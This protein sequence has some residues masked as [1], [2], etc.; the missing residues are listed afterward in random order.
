MR[1]YDGI[2]FDIDGT[3]WDSTD[4]VA[5]SYN[6]CLL[7]DPSLAAAHP[8][9][10]DILKKEFGKPLI[11]I[12]CDLF[13]E[14]SYKECEK[15]G[16]R[17]CDAENDY[18]RIHTPKPY[19][20]VVEVFHTLSKKLPLF[21]VSNCQKGYIEIFLDASSLAPYV[22]DF[23]SPGDSGKLKADNIRTVVG[24][25]HLSSPVYVGDTYGDYQASK[26][27]GVPFICASYGFGSVPEAECS[28]DRPSDLITMFQEN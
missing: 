8:I 17:L 10:G 2:I 13:P 28:I 15:W 5:D 1:T 19:E 20:G 25:N 3:L 21:I 27:A 11:E 16:E 22:K 4:I 9:T 6:Q 12:A 7:A 14:L 26:E 24:R 18:L 23:L